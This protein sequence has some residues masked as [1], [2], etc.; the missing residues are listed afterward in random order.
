[1]SDFETI[2]TVLFTGLVSI[3][4]YYHYIWRIAE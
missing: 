1:M 2:A 4:T 3:L